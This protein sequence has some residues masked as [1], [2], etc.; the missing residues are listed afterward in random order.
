[1]FFLKIT[2]RTKPVQYHH[3]IEII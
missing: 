1:L 2:K 3:V